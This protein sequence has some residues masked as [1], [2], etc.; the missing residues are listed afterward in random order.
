MP[1]LDTEENVFPLTIRLFGGFEADLQ[2]AP[3]P[4]LRTQKGNWLLALLA[5]Y[6]GR[7]LER[8]WVA[9]QLWPDSFT[10]RDNL[11]RSLTDLRGAMGTHAGRIVSLSRDRFMLDSTNVDIDVCHFDAAIAEA[12]RSRSVSPLRKAVAVYRGPLLMGWTADWID[13]KRELRTQEFLS[14]LESL[15][16]QTVEEGNYADGLAYAGRALSIDP[17][18]ESAYRIIM[19]AHAGRNDLAAVSQTFRQLEERLRREFPAQNVSPDPLTR[20]LHDALLKEAQGQQVDL[21]LPADKPL[22]NLPGEARPFIGRIAARAALTERIRAGDRLVTVTGIGG[23]G[24]SRLA[25]QVGFDLL[26]DFPEGVWLVDCYPLRDREDLLAA[27][28][29][30]LHIKPGSAGSEQALHRTLNRKKTLLIL[31]GFETIVTH[32]ACLEALLS[33]APQVQCLVTS[34]QALGLAREIQVPLE[35][36]VASRESP[37]ERE[38]AEAVRAFS[39]RPSQLG[40]DSKIKRLLER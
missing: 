36:M 20:T 22:H 39:G 6:A 3:L 18:L 10:P 31:D 16:E 11:K 21:T 29:A 13:P 25:R 19:R 24:K 32:A 35:P 27:I 23:M 40:S 2:G 1:F 8:E 14:A 38:L 7:P 5:L 26:G 4:S 15:A 34:R 17:L 30:A 37:A 33:E 9:E 28:C 12:K